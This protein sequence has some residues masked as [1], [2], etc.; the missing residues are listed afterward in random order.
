MNKLKLMG[1]CYNFGQDH[2]G[3]SE[4][5]LF[6]RKL[7]LID[8]LN[9]FADVKDLGDIDFSLC[10]GKLRHAR[11]KNAHANS[12]ANH[13]ISQTIERESLENEFL[14]HIGG[15]HGSALGSI[16]GILSHR[17]DTIV[18]WADAHGDINT[19][20]SSIT[21][22][23]HG[24]PLSFLLDIA[25][26]RNLF[27]WIKHSLPANQLIYIGPRDLD[28]AEKHIIKELNIQYFSSEDMNTYGSAFL[29][30]KA[31]KKIDPEGKRPI[32]LSFDVDIM[33][34]N[35]IVSTGTRVSSGPRLSEVF[36]IGKYLGETGRLRSMDVVELNPDIGN[37]NEILSSFY[38]AVEF[39]KYTLNP[40]FV[41]RSKGQ[42][43]TC[44][45]ST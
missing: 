41:D 31:M 32:H 43:L 24:M 16:H 5:P 15:D 29:L 37:E 34:Q 27:P 35:H 8:D 1:S 10:N 33:D 18:V 14:L 2:R 30:S 22:N 20:S 44:P 6:L 36:S 40:V 21:K 4:A 23:F 13:L 7:G 9:T 12:L 11:I 39:M 28:P 17:P 25:G 26:E 42:D 3:V 45:L 19:P 38:T